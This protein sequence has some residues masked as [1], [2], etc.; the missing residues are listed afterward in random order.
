MKE[1]WYHNLGGLGIIGSIGRNAA[2]R[3]LE[4]ESKEAEIKAQ[5][6]S[7]K[8]KLKLLTEADKEIEDEP[9]L[10]SAATTAQPD[11]ALPPPTRSASAAA[12]ETTQHPNPAEA[13]SSS[14][15]K[16]EKPVAANHFV[17]FAPQINTNVITIQPVDLSSIQLLS[18]QFIAYQEQNAKQIAVLQ[19]QLLQ[20]KAQL[21]K[22]EE[23]STSKEQFL[24]LKNQIESSVASISAIIFKT[25]LDQANIAS[26]VRHEFYGEDRDVVGKAL[27]LRAVESQ[28]TLARIAGLDDSVQQLETIKTLIEEHKVTTTGGGV[29]NDS[30]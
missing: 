23:S 15:S 9:L 19:M 14:A 11:E 28:L 26:C 21:Q 3:Y 5:D 30:E 7:K 10:T 2:A 18:S 6:E 16:E 24:A 29:Q 17:N 20:A 1:N 4:R 8:D 25:N 22:L 27:K 13:S 12:K